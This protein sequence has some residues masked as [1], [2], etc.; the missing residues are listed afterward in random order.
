MFYPCN[1]HCYRQ[2]DSELCDNTCDYAKAVL[3]NKEL[4]K[5]LITILNYYNWR[6]CMYCKNYDECPPIECNNYDNYDLDL[7]KLKRDYNIDC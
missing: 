3:E 5:I 2:Y 6:E 1:N 4:R 7:E